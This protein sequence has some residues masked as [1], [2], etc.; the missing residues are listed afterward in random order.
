MKLLL[1]GK[2]LL[3]G[4]IGTAMTGHQ[5]DELVLNAQD[6]HALYNMKPEHLEQRMGHFLT[7]FKG[8]SEETYKI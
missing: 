1:E 3:E 2:V 4:K 5:I 6:V 8:T 7:R